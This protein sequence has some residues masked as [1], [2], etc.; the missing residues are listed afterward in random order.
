MLFEFSSLK[1]ALDGHLLAIR[2]LGRSG[3]SRP[4]SPLGWGN[5]GFSVGIRLITL[6]SM[7]EAV[8]LAIPII[9]EKALSF[10]SCLVLVTPE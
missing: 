10:E 6:G 8:T 5:T 1:A 7:S 2:L 3:R 9:P 4:S